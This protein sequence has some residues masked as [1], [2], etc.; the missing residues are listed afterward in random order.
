MK[1][2]Q[3]DI[4]NVLQLSFLITYRGLVSFPLLLVLLHRR[5]DFAPP[6]IQLE[7]MIP[8]ISN[9]MPSAE[10]TDAVMGNWRKDEEEEVEEKETSEDVVEDVGDV[11]GDK[12][13]N[14]DPVG[15]RRGE[16]RRRER[17]RG[18]QTSSPDAHQVDMEDKSTRDTSSITLLNE[19]SLP[20]GKERNKSKG[21]GK[22]KEKKPIE[23]VLS[24]TMR[25][26]APAPAQATSE[27]SSEPSEALLKEIE[28]L[29]ESK[30]SVEVQLRDL[31]AIYD[32]E[33]AEWRERELQYEQAKADVEE[34]KNQFVH[35]QKTYETEKQNL[36]ESHK[37]E[38]YRLMQLSQSS[39]EGNCHTVYNL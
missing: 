11:T 34:M 8:D 15:E 12:G 3:I 4:K 1:S 10:F 24:S 38:K 9:F 29:R 13:T 16:E 33:K 20:L 19:E 39:H 17:E 36:V 6:H 37:E 35:K 2:I 25:G 28:A 7:K 31:A 27:L 26:V 21:K 14:S 5:M 32:E 22:K 23:S 18:A 30:I